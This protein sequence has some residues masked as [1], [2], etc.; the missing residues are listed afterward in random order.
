MS[1]HNYSRVA[2]EIA[3][4][5]LALLKSDT[6]GVNTAVLATADGFEVASVH[7]EAG[8]SGDKLAAIASSIHAL[9]TAIAKETGV[10][11]CKDVTVEG[12]KGVILLIEIPDVRNGLL[13]AVVA[14]EGAML[15]HL[16][17]ASKA[18]AGRLARAFS[19][20]VAA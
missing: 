11:P 3:K 9:G 5:E 7:A 6:P 19:P 15:G 17:W 16:L 4:R 10:A 14:G 1:T 13:L 8:Q 18:S 2:V 12:E 20:P